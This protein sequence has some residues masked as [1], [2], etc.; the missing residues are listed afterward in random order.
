MTDTT[1]S[2]STSAANEADTA[3]CT[4]QSAIYGSNEEFLAMAVPF[5]EGGLA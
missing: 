3:Q 1:T 4:H 5:L 2:G